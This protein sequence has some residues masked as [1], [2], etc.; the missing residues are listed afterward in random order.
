MTTSLDSL[1]EKHIPNLKAKG[2]QLLVLAQHE[3][4]DYQSIKALAHM[5]KGSSASLGFRSYSAL[6]LRFE[7]QSAHALETAPQAWDADLLTEFE[8]LIRN[9]TVHGSEIY[10]SAS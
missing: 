6:C 7:Q 1:I 9:L 2:F 4:I 10:E 5:L 3:P 8:Y